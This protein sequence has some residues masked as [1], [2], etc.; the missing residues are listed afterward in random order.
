MVIYIQPFH[1]FCDMSNSK[2]GDLSLQYPNYVYW[3]YFV[4]YLKLWIWNSR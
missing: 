1:A 3:L 4:L 2:I